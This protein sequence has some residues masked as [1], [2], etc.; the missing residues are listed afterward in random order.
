MTSR[1]L[2]TCSNDPGKLALDSLAN[3]I[4]ISKLDSN[5]LLT[6]LPENNGHIRFHEPPNRQPTSQCAYI[7]PCA[8]DRWAVDESERP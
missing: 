4:S 8:S 2:A 1:D 3:L 7:I 6:L 5:Y